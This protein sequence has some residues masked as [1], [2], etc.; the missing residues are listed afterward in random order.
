M[1]EVFSFTSEN[2]SALLERL[3]IQE[4]PARLRIV[5]HGLSREL[6]PE[7]QIRVCSGRLVEITV[8]DLPAARVFLRLALARSGRIELL[9]DDGPMPELNGL[10][11]IRRLLADAEQTAR[12]LESLLEPVGGL[13]AVVVTRSHR[14]MR[15]AAQLSRPGLE[16]ANF[17][18]DVPHSISEV[19]NRFAQDDFLTARS[20]D[21]LRDLGVL[22]IVR[23]EPVEASAPQSLPPSSGLRSDRLPLR[24]S[25]VP[26]RAPRESRR[27]TRRPEVLETPPLAEEIDQRTTQSRELGEVF[28]PSAVPRTSRRPAPAAI[29]DFDDEPTAVPPPRPRRSLA[30]LQDPAPLIG[31]DAELDAA[32][33]KPSSTT[34]ILVAVAVALLLVLY[35]ALRGPKEAEVALPVPA[36]DPTPAPVKTA[37]VAKKTPVPTV[38]TPADPGYSLSRPPPLAGPDADR[39]LREAEALIQAGRYEEADA[40]LSELRKTRAGDALVWLLTAHLET[41]RGRYGE[42]MR[43]V[44]KALSI[45]P[46]NYR[47][48]VIK[49]SIFQFEGQPKSAVRSYKTAL[50]ISPGHVMSAELRG[51]AQRLEDQFE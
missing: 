7:I 45:E 50:S 14:V 6:S 1:S 29:P 41:E 26:S 23:L 8:P 30:D 16:V 10:A 2:R 17:L 31:D 47:A 18:I 11:P 28:E 46:N 33:I 36:P 25:V 40:I 51:V 24:R 13:R 15:A 4:R 22:E 21:Q 5:L 39:R 34:P 27:P 3:S 19:L 48:H 38:S 44:D 12:A 32:G 9:P 43:A 20:L 42:A 49:G 37:T 35:F